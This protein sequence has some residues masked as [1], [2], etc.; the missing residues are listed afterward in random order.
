MCMMISQRELMDDGSKVESSFR[1]GIHVYISMDNTATSFNCSKDCKFNDPSEEHLCYH[2][3]HKITTIVPFANLGW[4]PSRAFFAD[5]QLVKLVDDD[6]TNKRP[7]W[8]IPVSNKGMPFNGYVLNLYGV[9]PCGRK[10]VVRVTNIPIYFDVLLP[11]P[12]SLDPSTRKAEIAQ[13]AKNVTSILYSDDECEPSRD[14]IVQQYNLLGFRRTKANYVRVH[15]D[16]MQVRTAAILRLERANGLHKMNHPDATRPLYVIASD[17][18]TNKYPFLVFRQSKISS[19]DWCCATKYTVDKQPF[20]GSSITITVRLEN[21]VTP[22]VEERSQSPYRKSLEKEPIMVLS[23]DIET[24]SISGEV[25][26][27]GLEYTI[28][29][30]NS[31]FVPYHSN[32]YAIS[33]SACIGKAIPKITNLAADETDHGTVIIQCTN[34]CEVLQSHLYV[35]GALRPDIIQGFNTCDFDHPRIIDKCKQYGLVTALY[36]NMTCMFRGSKVPSVENILQWNVKR[37]LKLKLNAE[38]DIYP[39]AVMMFEGCVDVDVR[40]CFRKLYIKEESGLSN[41]NYYLSQNNLGSKADMPYQRMFAIYQRS[42]NLCSDTNCHCKRMKAD[43]KHQC[44]PL[45]KIIDYVELS[46][47]DGIINYGESHSDI[48]NKCC[49]C[50]MRERNER[51]TGE[52]VFYSTVDCIKPQQL[53]VKRGLIVDAKERASM[54][55]TDIWTS[56]YNADSIRVHNCVAKY[57]YEHDI[58]FSMT[59]NDKTNNEKAHFVGAK[60]FE[61]VLGFNNKKPVSALDFES[62]YPSVMAAFNLS[63]DMLVTTKE[64]ADQLIAEGYSLYQIGPFDYEIE[65]TAGKIAGKITA[66]VVRH[67]G[68]VASDNTTSTS[69]AVTPGAVTPGTVTK[70]TIGYKKVVTYEIVALDESG[71]P[72]AVKNADDVCDIC[73]KRCKPWKYVHYEC[74][75]INGETRNIV[76]LPESV[77]KQLAKYKHSKIITYEP[78]LG[79][80]ALPGERMGAFS[81]VVYMLKEARR[82]IKRRWQMYGA[83][84][85]KMKHA[86]LTEYKVTD[87]GIT[88]ILHIDDIRFRYMVVN[89]KQNTVKLL[90]NTLYGISGSNTASMYRL[91]IAASVTEAGRN[92]ITEAARLVLKQGYQIQYGDTDSLYLICPPAI[93]AEMDKRYELAMLDI[94]SKFAGVKNVALPTTDQERSYKHAR[95]QAR[96][97]YWTAMVERTM[98]DL[99]QLST[100]ICDHF[101]MMTGTLFLVMAYEETGMPCYFTGKKKYFMTPHSATINFDEDA[102]IRGLE[103]VKQGRTKIAKDLGYEFLEECRSIE[104]ER[105]PEEIIADL[106]FKYKSTEQDPRLYEQSF[107]YKLPKFGKA[108][109]TTVLEFVQRMKERCE[110]PNLT[111]E[112]RALYAPPV[113]GEKFKT[114]IVKLPEWAHY[115][116]TGKKI[117]HRMGGRAEYTRVVLASRKTAQPLEID[118]DHYMDKGIL[119]IFA[120]FLTYMERCTPPLD[121]YPDGT[122]YTIKDAHRVRCASEYIQDTILTKMKDGISNHE[123]NK[124]VGQVY[125][126]RY[127]DVCN[128]YYDVLVIEHRLPCVYYMLR[129][130]DWKSASDVIDELDKTKHDVAKN[131]DVFHR[132][133]G[134]IGIDRMRRLYNMNAA[135]SVINVSRNIIMSQKSA[136]LAVIHQRYQAGLEVQNRFMNQFQ[137]HVLCYRHTADDVV[138]DLDDIISDSD[139]DIVTDLYNAM[140]TYR[141]LVVTLKNQLE[142]FHEVQ[143]YR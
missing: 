25:P 123:F 75:L 90:S 97:E 68:V 115:D 100:K 105:T 41:L 109:N 6:I 45:V 35:L 4:L 88:E 106:L 125:K 63:P 33:V 134:A 61:P 54:T 79:R 19:S 77:A 34:E 139:I 38:R 102:F 12:V 128:A 51:D 99:R 108:G 126:R 58:A 118:T 55:A 48:I 13:L 15:F 40:N 84:L 127:K 114:V 89:G 23:Y 141:A 131:V 62:L 11:D 64:E 1:E 83:I 124:D 137:D 110:D 130:F 91:E 28:T 31:I 94:A 3:N 85:E 50:G 36:R 101:V 49:A 122:E 56:F 80:D 59:G 96:K 16:S 65:G 87:N 98:I 42:L 17:D 44:T 22:T 116:L 18:S 29:M 52:V 10:I 113:V 82:P 2:I 78:I 95:I 119:T 67:S 26:R 32:N 66:W 120:R 70:I 135:N 143:K 138:I 133:V 73:N 9:T 71:S 8:F 92:Q 93:Y 132:M 121:K 24:F 30:I 60:V 140:L 5:Q 57:C 21:I 76:S 111:L 69:G 72:R 104:N 136:V 43:G 129:L 107:M 74:E 81:A 14:E 53:M 46:E 7:L 39:A 142:V 37:N 86:N 20:I 47:V 103:M 117:T 112:Q 27:D